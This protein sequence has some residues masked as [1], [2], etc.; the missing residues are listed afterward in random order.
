MDISVFCPFKK[1]HNQFA[2][3]WMTTNPGQKITI[4]NVAELAGAAFVKSF[5]QENITSAFRST[6]I[7]PFNPNTF[8]DDMFLPAAVKDLPLLSTHD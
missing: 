6:G 5:S 1:L 4:Y 8:P 3:A 7:L 2:D